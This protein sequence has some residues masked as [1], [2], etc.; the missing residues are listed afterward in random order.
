ME[1]LYKVHNKTS[2]DSC[3]NI[4][5]HMK[6]LLSFQDL[7]SSQQNQR[8]EESEINLNLSYAN[9]FVIFLILYNYIESRRTNNGDCCL[10]TSCSRKYKCFGLNR[11]ET[12]NHRGY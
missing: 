2:Y 3:I 7:S 11:T 8:S 12:K 6:D 5:F 10:N 9:D 4:M 1:D